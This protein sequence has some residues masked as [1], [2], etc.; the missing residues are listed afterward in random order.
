MSMCSTCVVCKR[1]ILVSIIMA[2][3]TRISINKW[4]LLNNSRATCAKGAAFGFDPWCKR[5][6]TSDSLEEQIEYHQSRSNII[7]RVHWKC[8]YF[9]TS[10]SK[11]WTAAGVQCLTALIIFSE[12]SVTRVKQTTYNKYTLAF[13][14]DGYSIGL[15]QVTQFYFSQRRRGH[16]QPNTTES[17]ISMRPT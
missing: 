4:E 13:S 8:R 16:S 1:L 11:H 15:P 10:N 17:G 7:V 6:W 14:L 3:L 2:E 12:I 5:Y 9:F